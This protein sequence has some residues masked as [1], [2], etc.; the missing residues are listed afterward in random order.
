MESRSGGK[1]Q[2]LLPQNFW[3]VTLKHLMNRKRL[4]Q[5]SIES[6]IKKGDKP[7]HGCLWTKLAAYCLAPCHH[8]HSCHLSQHTQMFSTNCQHTGM[9]NI[10]HTQNINELF[11]KLLRIIHFQAYNHLR[12]RKGSQGWMSSFITNY[13]ELTP[14]LNIYYDVLT[15]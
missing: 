14:I 3:H 15:T 8:L 6:E 2:G 4:N 13:D 10:L 12:H 7:Y 5:V 1:W 11:H 9:T